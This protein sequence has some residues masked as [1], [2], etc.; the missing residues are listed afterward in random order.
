MFNAEDMIEALEQGYYL[1]LKVHEGRHF[2]L[3][4][5]DSELGFNVYDPAYPVNTY[6]YTD[7]VRA[8]VYSYTGKSIQE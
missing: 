8:S 6:L 2:V 3:C 4:L 5:G 1:V 7:I